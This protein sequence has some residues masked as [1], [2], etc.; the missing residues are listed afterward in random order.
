MR[1]TKSVCGNGGIELTDKIDL[2]L[3]VQMGMRDLTNAV[4]VF[5]EFQLM[6]APCWCVIYCLFK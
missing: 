4:I 6:I 5:D 3:W 2:E 1:L